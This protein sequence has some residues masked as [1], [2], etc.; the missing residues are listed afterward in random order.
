MSD[1]DVRRS[2]YHVFGKYPFD[3]AAAIV[4][5]KEAAEGLLRLVKRNVCERSQLILCRSKKLG[6]RFEYVV[7]ELVTFTIEILVLSPGL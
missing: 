1:E 2:A 4:I 5:D 7:N 3:V 6:A